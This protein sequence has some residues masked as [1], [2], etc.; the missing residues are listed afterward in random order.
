VSALVA[1]TG[2]ARELGVFSGRR[3]GACVGVSGSLFNRVH[4]LN[5]VV[6]G[7]VHHWLCQ[8]PQSAYRIGCLAAAPP[9]RIEGRLRREGLT[10][11]EASSTQHV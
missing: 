5:R 6:G 7:A 8:A 2:Q 10:R 3:A 1:Q 11:H 4:Q 9:T